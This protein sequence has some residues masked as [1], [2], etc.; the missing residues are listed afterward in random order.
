[1]GEIDLGQQLMPNRSATYV[2]RVA[3]DS[4]VGAG[5]FDGDRVLVDRSLTA[6]EGD[7]VIAVVDGEFTVKRLRFCEGRPALFAENPGYPPVGLHDLVELSVWG[8]V[9]WVLHRPGRAGS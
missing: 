5:I 2:V 7:V 9:T 3:G 1:M 8:V 4:M 6:G